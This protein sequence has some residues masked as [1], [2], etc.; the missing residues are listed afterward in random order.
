MH[1]KGFSL[2]LFSCWGIGHLALCELLLSHLLLAQRTRCKLPLCSAPSL[3]SG[4]SQDLPSPL[5]AT[6]HEHLGRWGLAL[7]L[8]LPRWRA[9]WS[10]APGAWT[11][12]PGIWP[13]MEL[14]LFLPLSV[15]KAVGHGVG[16]PWGLHGAAGADS[17]TWFY[18]LPGNWNLDIGPSWANANLGYLC[19]SWQ[20]LVAS[21]LLGQPLEPIQLPMGQDTAQQPLGW[22]PLEVAGLVVRSGLWPEP[23]AESDPSGGI[24]RFPYRVRQAPQTNTTRRM[25]THRDGG[26]REGAGSCDDSG[27]PVLMFADGRQEAQES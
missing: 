14:D 7:A 25:W 26:F 12:T 27:W 22:W 8:R 11:D 4:A 1:R 23:R 16:A 6:D 5:P 15:S 10:G 9:L 18:W 24:A 20:G 21:G 17:W 19:E 13:S 2:T 3:D